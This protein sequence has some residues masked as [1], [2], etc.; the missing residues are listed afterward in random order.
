MLAP[1]RQTPENAFAFNPKDL[2]N[3]FMKQS[4]P[5]AT[6]WKRICII[7]AAVYIVPVS[8]AVWSNF[9]TKEQINADTA[10]DALAAVQQYEEK[11]KTMA[12][13]AVRRRFYR[14]LTDEQ[15]IARIREFAAAEEYRVNA[16][17]TRVTVGGH[18]ALIGVAPSL[19][20]QSQQLAA[21]AEL[22]QSASRPQVAVTMEEVDKQHAYRMATLRTGQFKVIAWGLLAWILPVAALYVFGPKLKPSRKRKARR[23]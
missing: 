19:G 3:I 23:F 21:A 8:F 15:V 9:P 12:P 18:E 14:G 5:K 4:D 20:E 1:A 22:A 11:Y 2:R 10:R 7:A 17:A 16:L 13:Q 6:K